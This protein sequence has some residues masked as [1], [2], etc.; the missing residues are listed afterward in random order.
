MI[1]ET[2]NGMMDPKEVI[3]RRFVDEVTEFENPLDAEQD[4][5]NIPQVIPVE[6]ILFLTVRILE[7]VD[8]GLA[9]DAFFVTTQR[10]IF[11]FGIG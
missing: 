2:G 11:G 6:H 8:E 5:S 7:E 4:I 1:E 3:L 10:M 9:Y